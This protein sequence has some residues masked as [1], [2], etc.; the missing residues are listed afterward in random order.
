[1]GVVALID[2]RQADAE[3][4]FKKAIDIDP[5]DVA[6]YE[7][8]ARLFA[9]TGRLPEAVKT[10]EDA[11]E[12]Q[13]DNPNLHHFLGILYQYAG[14][15]DKAVERYEDAIKYGPGLAEAKNNLAYIYAEAG[16][17]LDRALELAQEAKAALPDSHNA[18]DT[19][20]WVL[21]K[22]GVPSAAI[23]Y[24]KEAESSGADA[25][26]PTIATI[27]YHLALAYEL[28]GSKT[29]AGEAL[30]RS[31]SDLDGKASARRASGQ[32]ARPDPEWALPLRKMMARLETER[33][34][35]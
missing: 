3:T 4:A 34:S 29:E 15:R 32:A 8:L 19:L 12:I 22:R 33:N 26:A 11:V 18:A 23:S 30:E 2:Q 16:E 28:D 13:A 25:D 9:R 35:S 1:M 10:Y 20:G 7:H 14:E 24:L 17:K 27:R 21:F 31:L 5:T 6:G